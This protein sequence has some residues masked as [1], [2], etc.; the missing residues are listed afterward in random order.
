VSSPDAPGRPSALPR[1][2]L[3]E[4][5]EAAAALREEIE[6]RFGSPRLS[7]GPARWARQLRDEARARVARLDVLRLYEELRRRMAVLGMEERSA[8]VD[9]FGLDP[10]YLRQVRSV[11]D[12][13]YDRWWRVRVSGIERIPSPP[14]VLFV[15][16]RSG[17]LPYDGLMLAHAVEREHPDRI[18]PRFLILPRVGGVRACPENAARL[19][20]AGSP[21]IAFPEGQ[22]GALK[23][24]RERY[25]LQRFGR[26]GFVSLA[27]QHGVP[28]VP[29]AVVGAEEA[30]PLLF[31]PQFVG[32]L[33][34]VP[35]PLTATF[36]LLGPL[37]VIPLPSQWVLVFGEPFRFEAEDLERVDD[38]LYINRTREM[39]RSSV[40]SLVEEGLRMRRS[41]WSAD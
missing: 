5:H 3:Q 12:F 38:P 20:A 17:V 25:R 4:L 35:L 33:L 1:Q 14:R 27:I 11:L 19:L 34:G 6:R 10:T 16:N 9:E 28:I 15:A 13:L 40:Q 36:P 30:H 37:G 26:G 32:R 23:L 31:R 41:V 18:R 2:E 8:E 24:F 21:V 39:I 29:V 22:K 7:S